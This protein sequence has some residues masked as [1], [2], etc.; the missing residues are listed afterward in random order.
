MKWA[1]IF[2]EFVTPQQKLQIMQG[3]PLDLMN[4]EVATYDGTLYSWCDQIIVAK[5]KESFVKDTAW[6]IFSLKILTK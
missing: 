4:K 6:K 3:N 5:I 1:L 2:E